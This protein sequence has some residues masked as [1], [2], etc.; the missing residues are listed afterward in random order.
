MP[1]CYISLYLRVSPHI[2]PRPSSPQRPVPSSLGVI[3]SGVT[4]LALAQ[5]LTPTLTPSLP[6]TL[7]LILASTL[8]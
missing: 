8:P 4:I 7:T 3:Y 5:P 2:S 6:L 1:A